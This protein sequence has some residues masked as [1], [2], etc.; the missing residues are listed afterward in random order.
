[1]SNLD[2]KSVR[3]DLRPA[4]L[5]AT[6]A[7]HALAREEALD[8]RPKRLLEPGLATWSQFRGR[9]NQRDLLLLLL[10]DGAVTQPFA[11]DAAALLGVQAAGLERLAPE[12]VAGWIEALPGMDLKLPAQDYLTEQARRLALVTRLARSDLHR[13]IRPHH[14]VL[15]LPGTGGQLSKYLADTLEG[16]HLRDVFLIAWSDWHDR[17]LAGLAAVDAGLTGSAPVCAVPGIEA[18]RA[19]GRAFDYVIGAAPER[20]L[21]PYDVATLHA[22]FPGATVVLV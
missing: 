17:L 4:A 18:L 16:I 8:R 12:Q 1:M 9:M 5:F 22:W 14:H 20:G 3:P 11:F 7:L 10:E 6:A 2:P 19:G 13:G 15:E 21:Q